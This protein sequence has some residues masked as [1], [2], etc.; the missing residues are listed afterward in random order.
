VVVLKVAVAAVDACCIRPH[1]TPLR[2]QRRTLLWIA[3]VAALLCG[4]EAQ[5]D[6]PPSSAGVCAAAPAG[7]QLA[8]A[9]SRTGLVDLYWFAAAGPPVTFY[10]CIGSRAQRLGELSAQ[11]GADRTVLLGATRWSCD[12]QTRR[13]VA[14]T[15]LPGGEV[16][17]AAAG[18]R[19]RSCARRFALEVP[20][21]QAA[22]RVVSVRVVDR[23]GIGGIRTR[24]CVTSPAAERRCDSIRFAKAVAVATRRFR[25]TRRGHWRVVLQVRGHRVGASVAVG[26]RSLAA[27]RALPTLLA[28]GDSTMEGVESYLADALGR[29]ATV[30]SDARPGLALSG[31]DEWA[32]VAAA[33][34]AALHP[35]ITILS[36]GAN[37]GFPMQAG[38]VTHEC[39]DA[40]W[41]SEYT[42]RMRDVM[43]TYAGGGGRVFVLTIAAPRDPRRAAITSAVNAAMVDAAEGLAAV[44]V[45]RMDQLFSPDGYREVMRYGGD[46]IDVREADGVHLNVSGTAIEA[47]VVVQALDDLL[48]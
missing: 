32:P 47:R 42:Q 40:P 27:R 7:G 11:P 28:T 29:T 20:R 38:G 39:C 24:L 18:A 26:V 33:Q 21:R 37:E 43:R 17:F 16:V 34:V 5:G 46:D 6:A 13:F 36:I 14:T 35:D 31:H 45:L 41:V 30:I 10:E 9:T 19:T 4:A 3:V 1:T 48:S 8:T 15:S 22:G 12:R 25:A 23:W 44:R 2:L